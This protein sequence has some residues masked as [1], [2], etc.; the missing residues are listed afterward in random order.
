MILEECI[1][2]TRRTVLETCRSTIDWCPSDGREPNDLYGQSGKVSKKRIV[3]IYFRSLW[4]TISVRCFVE[5]LFSVC[6]LVNRV[7]RVVGDRFLSLHCNRRRWW[8][9][10]RE[11]LGLRSDGRRDCSPL[12]SGEC[13]VQRTGIV[14]DA[15]RDGGETS[16][17]ID[18]SRPNSFSTE[19]RAMMTIHPLSWT[20][21][22]ENEN[23]DVL[24]QRDRVEREGCQCSIRFG[25]EHQFDP[26]LLADGLQFG[27]GRQRMRL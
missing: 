13:S 17:W 19:R 15:D 7:D 27:I 21:F 9:T 3:T 11:M 10:E 14:L 4:S 16:D 24:C 25:H 22:Q 6:A 18:S 8:R 23:G 5:D 26:M 12:V 1:R 2:S 20:H